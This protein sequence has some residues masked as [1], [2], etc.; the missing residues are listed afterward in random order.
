[1][2]NLFTHPDHYT[3][4]HYPLRPALPNKIQQRASKKSKLFH[5]ELRHSLRKRR[6]TE[7]LV[8]GEESQAK[9]KRKISKYVLEASPPPRAIFDP[10]QEWR[11][12]RLDVMLLS[13]QLVHEQNENHH[14]WINDRML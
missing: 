11:N 6:I 1:M 5:I 4:V 14:G 2:L 9:K 10:D 7:C 13:E 12:V 8:A 3:F